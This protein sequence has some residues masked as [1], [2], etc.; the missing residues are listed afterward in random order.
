[1]SAASARLSPL[2][3]Y[4]AAWLDLASRDPRL[5]ALDVGLEQLPAW[6]DATGTASRRRALAADPKAA[7]EAALELSRD[8]AAVFLAAPIPFLVEAAYGP[9]ARSLVGPGLRATL[10][11]VPSAAHGTG[12]AAARDDL[13]AMRVLPQIAVAVPADAPTVAR[14]TAV[15]AS[16]DGPGYLRLPPEG[17]PTVTD[18]SFAL[19]R[20]PTLRDGNDLTLVA[21]GTTVGPALAVA[22]DLGR[23][24]IATR[25]LDAASV[26]PF[27]EA[28][29]LRAARDTG[30]LLVVED[31]PISTGIG[32]LVAAMTSENYPVPVRRLGAP[33]TVTS[34]GSGSPP[35]AAGSLAERLRDE[36]FELLRLRGKAT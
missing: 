13:A 25:V 24:G 23:V 30:A 34:G 5:G 17:A 26:K 32:T 27:D 6:P 4:R 20:A 19:G 22:D 35:G 10:V 1:M 12:E 7:V 33:E 15:L 3:A 31:G 9:V 28:A 2:Q 29:V 8:R 11:G 36:A 21:L 16:R 14:A 18:G